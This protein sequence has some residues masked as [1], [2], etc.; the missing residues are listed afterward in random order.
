MLTACG[1]RLGL[2]PEDGGPD[3]A[4]GPI[5]DS[6]GEGA[7]DAGEDGTADAADGSEGSDARGPFHDITQP[8]YWSTLDVASIGGVVSGFSGATFDGRYMYFVPD[9]GGGVARYDTQSGFAV[10][11][12]WSVFDATSFGSTFRGAA[13]DG[14]NVYLVPSGGAVVRYDTQGPFTAA[15]SWSSFGGAGSGFAGAVFD[16]QYMYLV[17]QSGTMARYDT[18][19]VFTAP[20]SW[21]TIAVT[22]FAAIMY[23]SY[24]GAVF[25]GRYVYV[26]TAD[27]SVS[28]LLRYD[29][30]SDFASSAS[31]STFDL[32]AV[33]PRLRRFA[34]AA[35][36]GRYVYLVPSTGQFGKIVVPRYDT[37]AAFTSVSSWSTFDTAALGHWATQGYPGAAFD[38]RY[39]YFGPAA[40]IN[41]YDT[42][43]SFSDPSSW[44]SFDTTTLGPN[45]M[46]LEPGVFDGRF[47]YFVPGSPYGSIAVRF[48]ARFPPAMPN[49]PAWHG[50]FF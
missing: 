25:D 35:F 9:G 40:Y 42:Q 15:S 36:D 44:S 17:G 28:P 26:A 43:A 37:G 27:A 5:D 33:D 32:L 50:S 47:L 3:V 22:A 4:V 10:A 23:P 6:G 46:L 24:L 48:D 38:G 41:R 45:V 29:T 16:G 11:A 39:V 34:G 12:S 49:L 31:W 18:H 30:Q 1:G 7:V 19:A 13:F 14:R 21:S 8:S 2:L 20:S